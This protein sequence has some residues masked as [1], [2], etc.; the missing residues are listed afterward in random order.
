MRLLFTLLVSVTAWACSCQDK[1]ACLYLSQAEAVFTGTVTGSK[2]SEGA[3]EIFQFRVRKA[4]RGVAKG[5]RSIAI[6][7]GGQHPCAARYQT[8]ETY[9]MYAYRMQAGELVAGYCSGSRPLGK[10][11]RHVADLDKWLAGKKDCA[12]AGT[13]SATRRRR[14]S[15]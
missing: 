10:A 12:V 13:G 4:Y 11:A 5:V 3:E 14:R 15:Q 6:S 7:G 2:V 1:I 8:G 9:L